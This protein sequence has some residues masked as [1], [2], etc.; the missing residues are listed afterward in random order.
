[1]EKRHMP[2]LLMLLSMLSLLIL[3]GL[4]LR[5]EYHSAADSF[6]RETNLL[7]RATVQQMHDSLSFRFFRVL[8]EEKED[9]GDSLRSEDSHRTIVIS[10]GS[11]KPNEGAKDTAQI[12]PDS[13]NLEGTVHIPWRGSPWELM[14]TLPDVLHFHAD[15]LSRQFEKALL[16]SGIPLP[17][18]II[19]KEMPWGIGSQRPNLESPE[20]P[21]FITSYMPVYH[22]FYAARFEEVRPWLLR[23]IYPQIGFSAFSTLIILLSFV[24]I[25][26]SLHIK[27]RLIEQKND[28]IGN[29][30]H[31]LM[32]PV[33]T[34]K[35][36]L[37]AIRRFDV[38]KD[39]DK[40]REY[41]DM[42]SHELNRLGMITEKILR[43]SLLDQDREKR[44]LPKRKLDLNN[45]VGQ[46]AD[47]FRLPAKQ[48]QVE[49][50]FAHEGDTT[51]TGHEEQLSLMIYHLVD[52]ALKYAAGGHEI[53]LN[54]QGTQDAVVIQVG[55]KGPG[56]PDLHQSKIFEKFYRI[57]AGN[58]HTVKGHGLG[59][60]FV[61]K[62][63]EGHGGR[64]RLDSK[65]GQG[66][67]FTIKLPRHG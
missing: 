66:S 20:P 63:V 37:E 39:A 14:R 65:S 9:A 43:V 28:L 67:L 44:M 47:S 2:G 52:N 29:I 25:Y 64:I 38:M 45:L 58:I 32:T 26:R 35:V 27:Q 56:I 53:R 62:V 13:L 50:H 51:V 8:L 40:T 61:K 41:L 60:Y 21:P 10:R 19:S 42:A 36:A 33:A 24:L 57:P 4:W 55:D 46:V 22:A 11:A 12:H 17:F 6:S 23:Q 30:T 16:A 5:A 31:E 18:E 7:Y 34:A 1:M 54:L 3:Q 59:L 15:T 48:K 49:I